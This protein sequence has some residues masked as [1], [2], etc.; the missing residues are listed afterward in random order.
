MPNESTKFLSK[1]Y[2]E[3]KKLKKFQNSQTGTLGTNIC[4]YVLK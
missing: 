2:E 1:L 4:K 3:N